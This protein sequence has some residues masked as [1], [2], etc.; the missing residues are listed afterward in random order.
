MLSISFKRQTSCWSHYYSKERNTTTSTAYC[1]KTA[2][3]F[4][5]MLLILKCKRDMDE[6]GECATKYDIF[7]SEWIPKYRFL[8][9]FMIATLDKKV[10]LL[11]DGHASHTKNLETIKYAKSNGVVLLSF[12]AHKP[13]SCG[14]LFKLFNLF[15]YID[16]N[17][18]RLRL[19]LGRMV[20]TFQVSFCKSVF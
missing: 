11:M 18:K 19:N 16:E 12:S 4:V 13:M 2:G 20:T 17:V 15:Y 8:L 3:N 9:L 10:V 7:S 5:L 6:L 14:A 1:A